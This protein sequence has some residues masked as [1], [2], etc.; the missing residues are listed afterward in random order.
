MLAKFL[1]SL[2]SDFALILKTIMSSLND[3]VKTD[4]NFIMFEKSNISPEIF[5][6]V[7]KNQNQTRIIDFIAAADELILTE[8]VIYL[9]DHLLTHYDQ[10][11][12]QHSLQIL[13]HIT[14]YSCNELQDICLEIICENPTSS[15][16]DFQV[17]QSTLRN[18]DQNI[19]SDNL[20]DSTLIKFKHATVIS[21]WIDCVEDPEQTRLYRK[22]PSHSFKLL[23]CGKDGSNRRN[24]ES[25]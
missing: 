9:K 24:Y 17:L 18:C 10:W 7:S 3:W 21:N 25:C 14:F 6:F 11:I 20:F 4:R 1:K 23:L 15:D 12:R 8:L 13:Y 19:I 16:G 22:S 5:I 2:S